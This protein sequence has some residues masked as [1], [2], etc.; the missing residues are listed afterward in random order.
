MGAG[1]LTVGERSYKCGKGVF[2]SELS[3]QLYTYV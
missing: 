3:V 2:A 1:F